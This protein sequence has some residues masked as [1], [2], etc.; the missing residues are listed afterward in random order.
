MGRVS[1]VLLDRTLRRI[2]EMKTSKCFIITFN[3]ISIIFLAISIGMF[4]H[5]ELQRSQGWRLGECE[6]LT[7]EVRHQSCVYFTVR[8]PD[9]TEACAIPASYVSFRAITQAP[10]C[11]DANYTD[12][13]EIRYWHRVSDLGTRNQKVQCRIPH[14]P[15][16]VD[17]CSSA[18]LHISPVSA[19]FET[20]H[21]R[22]VYLQY[23][24]ID[25]DAA[26][27]KAT[28]GQFAWGLAMLITSI[29]IFCS[30]FAYLVY[31]KI[32]KWLDLWAI[33]RLSTKE[34]KAT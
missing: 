17:T 22:F 14:N 19:V 25:G 18:A 1:R 4:V 9:K 10:A 13:A 2:Q 34:K 12:D 33:Y 32:D 29:V 23:S 21:M 11:I 6:L 20:W 15:V 16:R 27:R 31:V 7:K 30:Q 3:V 8:L 24:D 26:I 28:R 5:A